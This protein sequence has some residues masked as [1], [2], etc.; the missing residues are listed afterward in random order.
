MKSNKLT[1]HDA[2]DFSDVLAATVHDMKNSLGLLIQSIETLGNFVPETLV[3]AH[4]HIGRTHYEATRLN[5]NLVQ[6]L[7]LYRSDIED[8]PTNIDE[9]SID[10]LF[11]DIIGS[12]EYYANKKNIKLIYNIDT[13]LNWF[14]D[15]ELIYLLLNDA[16]INALRYGNKQVVLSANIEGTKDDMFLHIKIEDDGKGYP[17]SMLCNYDSD[18]IAPNIKNGRTGLGLFFAK[19]IAHAHENRG[20]HGE[21]S[22]SNNGNLGGSTFSVKLP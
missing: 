2:I 16:L 6:L 10:A 11:E 13:R 4:E 3:E 20:K 14:L 12:N 19:L 21:I 9:Y 8:F 22:L 18:P 7:S 5:S 1:T 15:S 17:K